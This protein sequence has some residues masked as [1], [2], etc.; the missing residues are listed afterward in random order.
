MQTV[1]IFRLVWGK[2][3]KI[4]WSVEGIT[5]ITK[6]DLANSFFGGVGGRID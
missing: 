2:S 3:G 1:D 4:S 6:F 5:L